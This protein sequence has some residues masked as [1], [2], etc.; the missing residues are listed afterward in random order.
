M[1][2][3]DALKHYDRFEFTD[4]PWTRTGFR[5]GTGPAVIIMHEVP[6][7]HRLGIDYADRGAASSRG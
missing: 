7:L 5:R 6:G 2:D 1:A 4:G 3:I